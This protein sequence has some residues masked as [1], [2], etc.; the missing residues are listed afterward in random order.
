M[1]KMDRKQAIRDFKEAAV[2][3]GV[4]AVKCSASGEAWVGLSRNLNAQKNGL[5]FQLGMGSFRTA[6]LQ[7]AWKEFGEPAFVF[8]V[9]EELPEDT[10]ELVLHDVLKERRAAWAGELGATEIR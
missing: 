5:W 7:K 4:F 1:S 10:P 9:L 3:R 8:E 2:P 6:S